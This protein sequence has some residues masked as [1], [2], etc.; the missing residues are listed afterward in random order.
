M[1]ADFDS[2]QNEDGLLE[3]NRRVPT[4]TTR[5]LRNYCL[6]T[7]GDR[8]RVQNPGNVQMVNKFR[9][10]STAA[11]RTVPCEMVSATPNAAPGLLPSS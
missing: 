5:A 3:L 4:R 6:S 2:A 7:C 10:S 11:K 9:L 1:F 8:D